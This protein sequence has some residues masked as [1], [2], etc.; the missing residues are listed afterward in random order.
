LTTLS[1]NGTV[2]SQYFSPSIFT[3]A[4][5]QTYQVSVADYQGETFSHWSDGTTSR[6]YTVIIGGTSTAVNLTAVYTP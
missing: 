5:G 3:V 6:V 1:Q 4:N 2:I